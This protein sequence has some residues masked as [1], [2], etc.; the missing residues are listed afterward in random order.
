MI[1][2]A[3]VRKCFL[4]VPAINR[5][6]VEKAKSIEVDALFL[7]LEDSVPAHQ[8]EQA[9]ENVKSVFGSLDKAHRGFRAPHVAIR[10]NEISSPDYFADLQLLKSTVGG[11]IDSVI[12]PKV[13]SLAEVEKLSD[14]LSVIERELDLESVTIAIDAQIETAMGLTNADQIASHPRVVSLSFGPLDFLADMLIPTTD[15]EAAP[16][17]LIN[18]ALI[19]IAISARA[20]GIQVFDGP[21]VD[22]KNHSA[23]DISCKR[24][25]GLGIDGKWAIHPDQIATIT[26]VF[27]PTPESYQ[28]ASNLLAAF[29]SN[30]AGAF[31]YNGVMVDAATLRMAEHIVRRGL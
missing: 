20:Y 16:I 3:P 17:D 2:G 1:Q 21:T 15:L 7:D 12:F 18:Y 9:R 27:T 6:M 26:A 13:N 25:V 24:A 4:A 22:Y 14:E 19:K 11:C 30:S 29:A 28:G 10:I 23:L 5:R 8:R 31:T